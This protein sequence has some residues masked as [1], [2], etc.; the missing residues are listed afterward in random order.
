MRAVALILLLAGCLPSQPSTYGL[1]FGSHAA[2]PVVVTRVGVN[3]GDFA[4]VPVLVDARSDE[5]MPRSTGV[6]SVQFPSAG[7]DVALDVEWVEVT[8]GRAYAGQATVPVKELERLEN[9]VYVAPVFGPNGL[10]IVTSDTATDRIDLAQICAARRPAGDTDYRAV[11]DSLP[12]LAGVL[13]DPRPATP[14]TP[15]PPP[16]E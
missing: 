16:E 5:V 11:P 4:M 13:S 6:Y 12:D 15:C 2:S 9:S 7:D 8:T 10:M 1:S 14:Q 3:G